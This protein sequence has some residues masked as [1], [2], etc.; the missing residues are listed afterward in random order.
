[1]DVVFPIVGQI[2]V[3][4]QTHL[5]NI[6]TSCQQIRGDQ[7]STGSRSEFFH[8]H[9]A[10]FLIHV[11]MLEQEEDEKKFVLWVLFINICSL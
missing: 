7:D 9:I 4:D 8:D 3:D 1:M 5:L 11:T 10:F 6:D 2:V